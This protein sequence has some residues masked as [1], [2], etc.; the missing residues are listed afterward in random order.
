[1]VVITDESIGV[2][3]LLKGHMPGLHPLKSTPMLLPVIA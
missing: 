1:M 2:S 3:Q